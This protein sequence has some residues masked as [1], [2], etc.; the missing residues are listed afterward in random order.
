M[1]FESYVRINQLNRR[2]DVLTLKKLAAKVNETML[3]NYRLKLLNRVLMS[4][5]KH[6]DASK[7]WQE[8]QLH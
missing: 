4:T 2:D 3:H 1:A 5:A 7:E 8:Y 6:L